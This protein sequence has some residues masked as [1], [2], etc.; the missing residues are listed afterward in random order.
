MTLTAEHWDVIYFIRD[1]Y[2]EH[3]VQAQVPDMIRHC[4]AIWG[5]ERGSNRTLHDI[6][7]MG[8]PQ[9]PGNRLAGIRKTKGEH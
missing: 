9:K 6:S 7:S 3:N 1:F 4:R 8:G 5:S 2:E